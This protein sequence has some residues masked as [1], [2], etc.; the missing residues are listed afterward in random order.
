MRDVRGYQPRFCCLIFVFTQYSLVS[1]QIILHLKF[2]VRC[3]AAHSASSFYCRWQCE[4]PSDSRFKVFI[5]YLRFDRAGSQTLKAP[6]NA[7]PVC[8]IFVH[9]CRNLLKYSCSVSWRR[10]NSYGKPSCIT[11]LTLWQP[12]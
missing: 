10:P 8:S 2:E 1:H 9:L 11:Y 3:I 5:S 12:L 7:H 6:S 4:A